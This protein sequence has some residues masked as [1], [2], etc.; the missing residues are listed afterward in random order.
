M[1]N[2]KPLTNI[3]ESKILNNNVKDEYDLRPDW[4]KSWFI[5]KTKDAK[6]NDNLEEIKKE[7]TVEEEH[8]YEYDDDIYY[9]ELYYERLNTILSKID[10]NDYQSLYY[11]KLCF[12]IQQL[13][14][15]LHPWNYY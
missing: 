2:N 11:E 14:E 5:Q 8:D 15:E 6:I 3:N 10:K 1:S 12:E 9:K 4:M 7:E 13:D